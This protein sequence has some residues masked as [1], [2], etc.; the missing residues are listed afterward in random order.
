MIAT[1]T[2]TEASSSEYAVA[3]GGFTSEAVSFLFLLFFSLF[4]FL[5]VH[6]CTVQY[7]LFLCVNIFSYLCLHVPVLF[8]LAFL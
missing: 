2:T 7:C 4:R 6:T 1:T 8:N 3:A 5:L